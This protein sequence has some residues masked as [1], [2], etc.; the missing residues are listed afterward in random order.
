MLFEKTSK[1]NKCMARFKKEDTD[2]KIRNEMIQPDMEER[3][4][5][6]KKKKMHRYSMLLNAEIS[7][8]GTVL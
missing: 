2:I 6:K 7:P 5:K 3:I 4:L 1:I 8:K